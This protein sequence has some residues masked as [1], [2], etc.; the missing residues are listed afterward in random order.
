MNPTGSEI[1]AVEAET[2][3]FTGSKSAAGTHRMGVDV[4]PASMRVPWTQLHSFVTW[5]NALAGWKCKGSKN[6]ARS[7]SALTSGLMRRP[8]GWRGE[9]NME[10]VLPKP[11]VDVKPLIRNWSIGVVEYWS[12]A[13]KRC[14]LCIFVL[15]AE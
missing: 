8:L 14:G 4:Q 12:D 15:G 7:N 11:R 9:A 13:L 10:W 3:S 2:L 1:D 5:E 6:T